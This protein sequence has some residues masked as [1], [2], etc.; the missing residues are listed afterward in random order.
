VGGQVRPIPELLTFLGLAAGATEEDVARAVA[1][2][3]Q[4][5]LR[6]RGDGQLGAG[7]WAQMLRRT[8][9]VIPPVR[10]KKAAWPVTF[11]GRRLGILEKTA[12]YEV[13]NAGGLGGASIQLG[14]RV[15]DMDAVRRAGFVDGG[16]DN[17][18]WIQ[19]IITNRQLTDTGIIRRHGRY[20]DPQSG[21]RDAHPYYWD[22]PGQ[23]D[24]RFRIGRFINRQAFSPTTPNSS[25]LCYDLIF[26]D[27]PKRD[28]SEAAPG[29]RVYWN[30]EVALVGV[31]PPRTGSAVVRNVI[32]NTVFW[33]F[34]LVIEGGTPGVRLNAISGGPRGGT[35]QFKRALS[36]AMQTTPPNFPNHCFVGGG[37]S[38]AARCA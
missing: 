7:T 18:R 25:R 37:F 5:Q 32:L 23:G 34:D 3:Q 15:T 17:F 14:F 1:Q 4:T 19:R 6:Q 10:F 20:V 36:E 11:N 38:R 33:G 26:E 8:P 12:P 24:A 31:R 27:V 30:A 13:V 28:L 35:V 22:N 16:E 21:T 9:P 2:W 29:R